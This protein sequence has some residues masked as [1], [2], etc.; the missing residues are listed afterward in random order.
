MTYFEDMSGDPIKHVGWLEAGRAYAKGE[1]P[2]SDVERLERLTLLTWKPPFRAHGWHDCTLCGRR[3]ADGPMKRTI[4]GQSVLL[5][6]WEIFVP[7]GNIMYSTPTLI[8]HYIEDHG[9]LPPPAF[10]QAL[11][12]ADPGAPAYTAAC[13]AVAKRAGIPGVR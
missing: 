4:A 8:L 12:A 11:R 1:V 3:P 9:Y 6:A 2:K 7:D 13:S 5:G 10:L